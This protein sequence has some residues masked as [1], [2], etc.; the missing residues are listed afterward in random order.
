MLIRKCV[1]FL[2]S[3]YGQFLFYGHFTLSYVQLKLRSV[4][5]LAYKHKKTT[6][7]TKNSLLLLEKANFIGR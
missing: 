2:W 7:Y 4:T 5:S 3:F 6:E 1:L